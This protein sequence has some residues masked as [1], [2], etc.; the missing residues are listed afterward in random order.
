MKR[1]IVNI[2][3]LFERQRLFW[4]KSA[5]LGTILKF[6]YIERLLWLFITHSGTKVTIIPTIKENKVSDE[7]EPN[8]REKKMN[9]FSFF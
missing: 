9:L 5:Q 8:K 6:W 1:V 2:E 7:S 3:R 4:Q